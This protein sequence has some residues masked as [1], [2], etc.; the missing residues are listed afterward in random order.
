MGCDCNDERL[1]LVIKQG[2]QRSYSFTIKDKTGTPVDLSS[3]TIEVQVKNYPLYKVNSILTMPLNRESSE[4][5]QITDPT[6]GKF[7]LTITE[8]QSSSLVPKEY[9][10]IITMITG[11]NRVIISG[12]GQA[13]GVL[14]VCK[15]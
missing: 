9:Y 1:E 4:N 5:G 11:T 12:E 2:E 13:S 8:E 14:V 6:N 3:S 10:L 15:Q 7:V